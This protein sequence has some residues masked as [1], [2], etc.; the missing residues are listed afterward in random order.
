M[1]Y[2]KELLNMSR[3]LDQVQLKENPPDLKMV[4]A[5]ENK[6]ESLP[7]VED[8]DPWSLYLKIEQKV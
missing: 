6:G 2:K 8:R 5:D 4:V 7:E 3:R 1:S